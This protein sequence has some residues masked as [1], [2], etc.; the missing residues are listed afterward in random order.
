MKKLLIIAGIVLA[1]ATLAGCTYSA[2]GSHSE[3]SRAIEENQKRL[4][5]NYQIPQLDQSLEVENNYRRLEFLNKSDA[6][7]Y[8]YLLSYGKVIAFYTIQGKVSSLNSYAT[9]MEQIVNSDGV[10][11]E[12][13][14]NDSD[15][16]TRSCLGGSGYIVEAPDIDGSYGQNID[17]VYFFTTEGAYVEWRGEY[18][19]TSE[20]LK[21]TQPVELVRE[22]K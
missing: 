22:V 4:N 10:P 17:G 8:V 16:S 7:G 1:G 19:Y 11:C 20:P 5:K 18:V 14:N 9:A 2:D 3:Q 12:K 21:I 6:I 13:A 15:S